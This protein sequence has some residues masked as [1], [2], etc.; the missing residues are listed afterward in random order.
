MKRE[1]IKTL[2][3]EPPAEL[4]GDVARARWTRTIETLADEGRQLPASNEGV[5]M[6]YSSAFQLLSECE[7]AIASDG[8]LVDGGRDGKRRHPA[9]AGKTSALTSIRS[10][11]AQLA[12]SPTSAKGVVLPPVTTRNPFQHLLDREPNEFDEF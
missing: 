6:A 8:L 11:A 2:T 5:L 7:A 4:S 1:P 9:L 12:L 3:T 10:L